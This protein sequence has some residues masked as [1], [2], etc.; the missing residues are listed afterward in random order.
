MTA[1]LF[2]ESFKVRNRPTKTNM[3]VNDKIFH[4]FCHSAVKSGRCYDPMRR[5]RPRVS[6]LVDLANLRFDY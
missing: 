5:T 4:T 3:I 2:Q 1:M 6:R